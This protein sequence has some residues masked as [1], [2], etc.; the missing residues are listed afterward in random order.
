M[1]DKAKTVEEVTIDEKIAQVK[2]VAKAMKDLLESII[3]EVP[4]GNVIECYEADSAIVIDSEELAKEAAEYV[5]KGVFGSLCYNVIDGYRHFGQK[6]LNDALDAVD[7]AAERDASTARNEKTA[8]RLHQ[9]INWACRMDVQQSYRK[10][11][12][13]PMLGLY[14]AATGERYAQRVATSGTNRPDSPEQSVAQKL[15][16]RRSAA[17]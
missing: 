11:L 14:T 6:S 3:N 2:P 15:R 4:I 8:D 16:E 10:A 13:T 9:T 7:Q 12:Q 1:N 5:L 17:S